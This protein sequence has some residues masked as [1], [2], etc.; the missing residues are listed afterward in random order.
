[1]KALSTNARLLIIGTHHFDAAADAVNFEA[2][3]VLS[4]RRQQEI[5]E[6]VGRLRKFNPSKVAV[7]A[8]ADEAG[9]YAKR[10]RAYVNGEYA[11]ERGE[12]YQVG[13]RLA[14]SLGHSQ[15]HAIDW[16][17]PPAG[18]DTDVEAFAASHGQADLLEDALGVARRQMETMQQIQRS[19]SLLD[20][21][22]YTNNPQTLLEGHRLYYKIARIRTAG[23]FPGANWVQHWYGRNLK[24]Y[25]NLTQVVQSD[26]ERMLLLI[27]AGY[28]WLLQQF[29][30]EDGLFTLEDAGSYLNG[31]E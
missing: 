2:D 22:R 4:P 5:A 25:M 9:E 15:V 30:K 10:Y 13:F 8:P 27:G 3:D 20:L 28:V 1:M 21:Y 7:Q 16:N 17:E 26:D 12:M 6:L 19:G 31:D 11:S 23:Q 24:I 18:T 14:K 29:A